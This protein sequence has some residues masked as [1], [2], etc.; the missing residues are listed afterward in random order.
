MKYRKVQL[1]GHPVR[2]RIAR[3]LGSASSYPQESAM[4]HFRFSIASLLLVVLFVAVAF[5]ALR[6]ADDLWDSIVFSLTVGLLLASVLLAIHRTESR[7]AFWLG[8]A[9]CGWAYLGASLIP[10]IEARLLTTRALG[11]LSTIH[12]SSAVYSVS[13]TPD[14][15]TLTGTKQGTVRIWDVATGQPIGWPIGSSE[16]FVQIG[17][18][19]TALVLAFLGG[20]LSR[21]LYSRGHPATEEVRAASSVPCST[22]NG[23]SWK[24]QG[25]VCKLRPSRWMAPEPDPHRP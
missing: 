6:K 24:G 5:A 17:H 2:F 22:L 20:P 18:S 11:I 3:K 15:R 10:P 14:G 13:F 9:L 7:R 12:P 16:N 25:S 8:F 21:S 19:L 4:R 1:R 23:D